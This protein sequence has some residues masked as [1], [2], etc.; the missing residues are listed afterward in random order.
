[1]RIYLE[2]EAILSILDK[3]FRGEYEL[4][5]SDVVEYELYQI[6]DIVKRQNV[7]D[8]YKNVQIQIGETDDIDNRAKEIRNQS[9]IHMF[10]SL[11]I[12]CA[13]ASGADV[14]LTTDD[15]LER[16]SARLE[17]NVRIMNPSKFVIE[18]L[19]GR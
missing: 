14:L 4:L 10:D 11:Q 5:G 3:G 6:R 16:M 19:Y 12:A 7:L 9:K 18:M 1:M 8:L 2:S 17:L 15:R 13:E